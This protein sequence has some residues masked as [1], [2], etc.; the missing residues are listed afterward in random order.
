MYVVLEYKCW[1]GEKELMQSPA[2][3]LVD[4]QCNPMGKG[5]LPL[6][7]VVLP[8]KCAQGCIKLESTIIDLRIHKCPF[9]LLLFLP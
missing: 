7:S 4:E 5:N 1:S 9:L 3:N 8:R 2:E 6:I